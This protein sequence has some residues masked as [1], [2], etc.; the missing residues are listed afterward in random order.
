MPGLGQILKARLANEAKEVLEVTK[1]LDL[2]VIVNAICSGKPEWG[3]HRNTEDFRTIVQQQI[4]ERTPVAVETTPSMESEVAEPEPPKVDSLTSSLRELYSRKRQPSSSVEQQAAESAGPRVKRQR[5]QRRM[6]EGAKA[7]LRAVKKEVGDAPS[8]DVGTD[9][10]PEASEP[11]V[12]FSDVGGVES[13][14][15]SL[16]EQILLPMTHPELYAHLG[17]DWPRGVLLCG[18]PG[19][20]K[21]MVAQACAGEL[22]R[23]GYPLKFFQVSAPELVSGVSGDSEAKIRS[24]FQ[25]AIDNAPTLLFIDEIDAVC[26]KRQTAQKE[27]E[28]RI[29]AQFLTCFDQLQ[30]LRG[31]RAN[32]DASDSDC[33]PDPEELRKRIVLVVGATNRPESIDDA[34]RRPGRFDREV[35]MSTPDEAA[36]LQILQVLCR[37]MRLGEDCDLKQLAQR[38]VG[39]VGADLTALTKEA[40]VSAVNRCFASLTTATTMISADSM[41]DEF[42]ALSSLTDQLAA[43]SSEQMISLSISQADLIDAVSKVQPS[44]KREGFAAIPDVTFED[45]GALHSLREELNLNVVLP[46][47]QPGIFSTLGLNVPAGV[48]L[49]GPP[50][51][52]KT[53]LAKACA[54]ACHASFLSVKG[55]EL[56][57][58]YVGESEKAV[59]KVFQRSVLCSTSIV[60]S[61][62]VQCSTICS[63]YHLL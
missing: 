20:G 1:S 21:T 58:Q 43:F 9:W 40:A 44:G 24:L 15:H 57:N 27:M 47:A 42:A 46:I 26:P 39:Y 35:T 63:M 31:D 51:C 41:S 33:Q 60:S 8:S 17:V 28:R 5:V 34:L 49:F 16:R 62:R 50:G 3:R 61:D 54:A 7:A 38:T 10:K 2:D 55:P 29:V 59:R 13:I 23:S 25:T 19:C 4:S 32:P 12:T 52:G 36:R 48:L 56:L 14:L 11:S 18:P 22:L 45:I 30:G 37:K 53:L 6:S